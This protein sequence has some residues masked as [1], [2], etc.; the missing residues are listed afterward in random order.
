MKPSLRALLDAY[1]AAGAFSRWKLETW[2]DHNGPPVEAV[3]LY[4][5]SRYYKGEVELLGVSLDA[6]PWEMAFMAMSRRC[7]SIRPALL[8]AMAIYQHAED[9]D[10]PPVAWGSP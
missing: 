5:Y 9:D 1:V 4:F 10:N 7:A 2:T 6:I 3:Q 8:A